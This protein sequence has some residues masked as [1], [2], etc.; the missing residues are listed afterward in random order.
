[1]ILINVIFAETD[2]EYDFKVD[3]QASVEQVTEEMV[4]VIAEQEHDT[5]GKDPGLFLLCDPETSQ[6]FSPMTTL[7]MNGVMS[8][9]TLLL[10]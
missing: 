6:I 8:G 3:E 10:V 5:V 7:A 9:M 2:Q 1:M 4:A